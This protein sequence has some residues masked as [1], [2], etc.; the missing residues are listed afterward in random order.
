MFKPDSPSEYRPEAITGTMP[1]KILSFGCRSTLKAV[2]P[3]ATAPRP[4]V[5][6]TGFSIQAAMGHPHDERSGKKTAG[7][8]QM[9]LPPQARSLAWGQER[10]SQR[11]LGL[12]QSGG[13]AEQV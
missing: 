13:R 9:L 6:I 11:E 4:H 8:K 2:R 1:R 5:V 10:K 12:A 3:E 7:G